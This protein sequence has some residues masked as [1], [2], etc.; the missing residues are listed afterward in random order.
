MSWDIE[1]SVRPFRQPFVL[2]MGKRCS[3]KSWIGHAIIN[4]LAPITKTVWVYEGT[5]H[6]NWNNDPAIRHSLEVD[7][8]IT[9]IHHVWPAR[10]RTDDILLHQMDVLATNPTHSLMVCIIDDR[11]VPDFVDFAEFLRSAS[12]L[13]IFVVLSNQY[14]NDIPPEIRNVPGMIVVYGPEMSRPVRKKLMDQWLDGFQRRLSTAACEKAFD[15]L[16]ENYRHVVAIDGEL[17]C[18]RPHEKEPQRVGHARIAAAEKEANL[19]ILGDRH[20][21]PCYLA[22]FDLVFIPDLARLVCNY[23]DMR[24]PVQTA[25]DVVRNA[26]TDPDKRALAQLAHT[27]AG[28]EPEWHQ[29]VPVKHV[30]HEGEDA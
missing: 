28:H 27:I 14:F 15:M 3:G 16:T 12:Q 8:G 19:Q 17:L 9:F 30:V 10:V 18:F 6:D 1:K 29:T 20:F 21:Q 26:E 22:A 2:N 11:Q 5:P 24:E 7:Q 25:I 4:A 23:L 13:N